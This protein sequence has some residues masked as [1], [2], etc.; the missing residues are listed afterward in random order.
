MNEIIN[1]FNHPFFI[2]VGGLSTI[3]AILSLGY[4]VYVILSGVI[5]VWIRLGKSLS[6]KKIAIYAENDFDSLRSLLS[7]SGIFKE[8]NIDKITND[9]LAKGERHTMM[10]VNYV[11]FKDKI[12]DILKYKKDSDAL[13]LYAPHS[14]SSIEQS[15]MQKINES[16]NSVVVNMRGRLL[17]DIFTS[18]ITTTYEKR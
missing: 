17:N 13:I 16:R 5:P 6:N 7:D 3:I 1:F 2:I 10:L 9:S 11:E 8:K 4:G 18:M 12:E 14:S 15:L